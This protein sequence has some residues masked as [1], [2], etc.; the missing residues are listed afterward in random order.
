M[1]IA[2]ATTGGNRIRRPC[3]H[4]MWR[5]SR[6]PIGETEDMTAAQHSVTRSI[7]GLHGDRFAILSVCNRPTPMAMTESPDAVRGPTQVEPQSVH[8]AALEA[9]L[10]EWI[11]AVI[12][13]D[14]A[15]FASLYNATV[16]RAWSV[17]IRITRQPEAAEEVVEDCFWQVWRDAHRFDAERGRVLTWVLT[18]CRSR[19]LDYLRR[20][21]IAEPMAD[22][23]TLRSSELADDRDPLDILGATDRASA[24]HRALLLLKPKERQL[25]SLAFFRGLTHQEIAV[26]CAMPIGTVKT[27]M[28]KAFRQMRETLGGEGWDTT[29]E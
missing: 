27:T 13:R 19:A 4:L 22:I 16:N 9:N 21:D 7:P 11:A 26:A 3:V 15:A 25:I 1:F 14:E 29:D 10:R 8:D 18:I 28:T 5:T 12:R 6:A 23:E 20:K 2:H 17:A 24:V